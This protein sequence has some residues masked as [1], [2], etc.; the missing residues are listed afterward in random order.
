MRPPTFSRFGTPLHR[1][2]DPL[3]PH[4]SSPDRS[5]VWRPPFLWASPFH[6]SGFGPPLLGPHPSG[7]LLLLL[8]CSCFC[9]FAAASLL[10]LLLLLLLCCC[11]CCFFLHFFVFF[12]FFIFFFLFSFSFS[13]SSTFSYSFPGF[14]TT[15]REPKRVNLRV[16][17]LQ[18]PP[19][20]HEKTLRERDKKSENGSWRM[21]KKARNFGPSP[22]APHP[23]NPTLRTA[24][25][26]RA[27]L[28]L[29]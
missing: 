11:V 20:F 24:P 8:L 19:K 5:A 23:S 26:L 29:F 17:A 3:G 7:L 14:H 27:G 28:P 6:F 9:C 25:T 4:A 13:L 12:L 15:A 2:P 18:T 22:S 1:R 21:K 10:I 16:P